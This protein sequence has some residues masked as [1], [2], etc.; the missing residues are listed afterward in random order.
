MQKTQ[1]RSHPKVS[2]WAYGFYEGTQ[3]NLRFIE[4]GGNMDD[5]FSAL[6]TLVPEKNLGIFVAGNTENGG[7]QIAEAIKKAIFNRC[8]PAAP[9]EMP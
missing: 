4:H 9:P 6:M 8:F 3:N 1:F 5:G 2:G 7:S